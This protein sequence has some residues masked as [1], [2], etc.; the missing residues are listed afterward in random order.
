MIDAQNDDAPEIVGS[1]LNHNSITSTEIIL[2]VLNAIEIVLQVGCWLVHEVNRCQLFQCLAITRA[3]LVRMRSE[4]V[5]ADKR[6]SSVREKVV[7]DEMLLLAYI[8]L[9]PTPSPDEFV[10]QS[11]CFL[12]DIDSVDSFQRDIGYDKEEEATAAD[13]ST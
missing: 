11:A 7:G 1:S 3:R 5:S 12:N 2:W 4:R 6:E 13:D 8:V 10:I 9:G